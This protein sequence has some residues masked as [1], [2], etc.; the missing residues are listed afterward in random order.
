ML[1]QKKRVKFANQQKNSKSD[2]FHKRETE[3]ER[4][5]E[6]DKHTHTH[7]HKEFRKPK[8]RK[9]PTTTTTKSDCFEKNNKR[10][11]REELREENKRGPEIRQPTNFK[12]LK[13]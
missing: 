13:I 10:T 8:F 3:R 9:T 2:F 11:R 5:R 12:K 4:K 6:K 1:T 7:T